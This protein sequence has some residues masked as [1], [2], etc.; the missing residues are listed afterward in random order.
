MICK[1]ISNRLDPLCKV[2][3]LENKPVEF[4]LGIVSVLGETSP[5]KRRFDRLSC[6]TVSD[7]LLR[8]LPRK[9]IVSHTETGGSLR[10]VVIE[11]IPLIGNDFLAHQFH[12]GSEKTVF[13]RKILQIY[14]LAE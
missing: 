8:D 5:G 3:V 14:G 9:F 13:N 10:N 1:G 4:I 6:F 7:P 2:A 12:L 11:R